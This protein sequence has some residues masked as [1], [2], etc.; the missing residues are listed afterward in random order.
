MI[1]NEDIQFKFQEKGYGKGFYD[2][3]MNER[4]FWIDRIKNKIEKVK[5]GTFDTEIILH[6]LLEYD[7]PITITREKLENEYK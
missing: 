3:Q 6:Q 5:D 1:Y 4:R 2:G 7:F